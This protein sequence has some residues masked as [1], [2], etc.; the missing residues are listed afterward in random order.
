IKLHK[1]SQDSAQENGTV[2]VLLIHGMNNPP[3]GF[4]GRPELDGCTTCAELQQKLS[5]NL[6]L[7]TANGYGRE[8]SKASSTILLRGLLRN[9]K[10]A[11]KLR[12]I[13]RTSQSSKL[14]TMAPPWVTCSRDR[15]EQPVPDIA[16]LSFTSPIGLSAPA[17][18]R[19]NSLEVG[20][21]LSKARNCKVTATLIRGWINTA[22]PSINR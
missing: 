20:Q 13:Q 1:W 17:S 4:A 3:F 5:G 9:W 21:G 6:T 2:R 22:L 11:K 16:P 10:S 8:Q 19:S 7:L 14:R 18:A 15:L 12:L